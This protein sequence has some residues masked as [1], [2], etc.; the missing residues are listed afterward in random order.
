[1]PEP[2]ANPVT[3]KKTIEFTI[4]GERFAA[5]EHE[6]TARQLL[7]EDAHLDPATHY[8]IW[9][10]GREQTSFETDPDAP[11]HLHEHQMFITAAVGPTP[12]S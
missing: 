8:L 9:V 2:N 7:V 1:M 12:V 10:H 5:P 3:A 11:I 4:D 6:V